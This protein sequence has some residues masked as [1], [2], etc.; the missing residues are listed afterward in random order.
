VRKTKKSLSDIAL[1]IALTIG[2]AA[3]M[4]WIVPKIMNNMGNEIIKNMEKT[5][6]QN[7]QNIKNAQKTAP[8]FVPGQSAPTST[9]WIFV[10][11][12]SLKEC[13]GPNNYINEA[14][15]RCSRDHYEPP[16]NGNH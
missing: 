5:Q 14:T 12:K 3:L 8:Q 6:K 9:N 13:A 10:K 4:M 16:Q 11:G 1:E 15:L 7:I 2:S